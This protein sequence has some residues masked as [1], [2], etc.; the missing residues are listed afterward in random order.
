M[1]FCQYRAE[2]HY[3]NSA[4]ILG[5]FAVGN[6]DYSGDY[7]TATATQKIIWMQDRVII[8]SKRIK[9]PITAPKLAEQATHVLAT[10]SDAA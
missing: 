8:V 1:T 3:R 9:S 4:E 10:R 7:T 6:H 2:D 5:P